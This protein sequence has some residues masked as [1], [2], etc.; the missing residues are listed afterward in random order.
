MCLT[1]LTCNPLKVSEDDHSSVCCINSGK[2]I[3]HLFQLEGQCLMHAEIRW[4]FI[5]E[6]SD[7]ST[8]VV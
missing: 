7:P 8:V 6:P 1:S 2:L 4:C 5:N 3:S